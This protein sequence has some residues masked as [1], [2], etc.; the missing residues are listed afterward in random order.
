MSREAAASGNKRGGSN[1]TWAKVKFDRQIIAIAKV[2]G[3]TTIY[4]D[5]DDIEVLGKRAKIDVI[6]LAQ[7]PL[8]PQK[9]QL[10]LLE[11]AAE[12]KA[13]DQNQHPPDQE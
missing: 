1:A 6:G 3:A 4:S 11:H 13:D 10:D 5:D 2:N 7:L 8:P 12:S 9:A